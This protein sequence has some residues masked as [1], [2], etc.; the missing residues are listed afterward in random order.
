[1]SLAGRR[2]AQ[3]SKLFLA[4]ILMS[5]LILVIFPSI[6]TVIK[7]SQGQRYIWSDEQ[8]T[9][10]T[11]TIT[12]TT[13]TTATIT[14]RATLTITSTATTYI[15]QATVTTVTTSTLFSIRYTYVY[16]P[17]YTTTTTIT[18]CVTPTRTGSPESFGLETS[19]MLPISVCF[20]GLLFLSSKRWPPSRRKMLTAHKNSRRIHED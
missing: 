20:L 9:T 19:Y 10:T 18:V 2:R 13:T 1:M 14:S 17:T 12:T 7:P 5:A 16:S 8:T 3:E 15:A 4:A 6:P 11:R